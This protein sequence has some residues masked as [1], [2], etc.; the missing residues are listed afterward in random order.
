M[1][2]TETQLTK[3]ERTAIK[4]AV[5]SVIESAFKREKDPLKR[6]ILVLQIGGYADYESSVAC[7]YRSF[8]E[9]KEKKNQKDEFYDFVMW[10]EEVE[11]EE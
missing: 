11:G 5:E 9:L 6:R 8:K 4:E 3:E 10:R 2:D 7:L 1:I